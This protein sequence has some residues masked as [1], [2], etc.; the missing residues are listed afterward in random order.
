MEWNEMGDEMMVLDLLAWVGRWWG[1]A[2]WGCP[3]VYGGRDI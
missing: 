2:W 1:M 3:T